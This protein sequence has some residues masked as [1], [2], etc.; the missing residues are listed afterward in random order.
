MTKDQRVEQQQQQRVWLEMQIRE[1]KMAR[2]VDEN[3]ERTWQET[4]R[5]T[6]ERAVALALLES[7]CR[8]RLVEANC[9]YNRALVCGGP[10]GLEIPLL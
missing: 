1:K 3:A 4:E 2:D 10:K 5:A 6:T 9:R 8:R 7:E